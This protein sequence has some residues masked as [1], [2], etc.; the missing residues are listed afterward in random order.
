[1]PRRKP[2]ADTPS[3]SS[4][5]HFPLWVF[6]YRTIVLFDPIGGFDLNAFFHKMSVGFIISPIDRSPVVESI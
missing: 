2:P 6:R 4:I 1:M 5:N 3:N